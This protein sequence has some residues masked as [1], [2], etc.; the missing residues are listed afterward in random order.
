MDRISVVTPTFNRPAP[1]A[2]ALASLMAQMGLEDLAPELIVV[3]D[4]PDSNARALVA[5]LGPGSPFPLQYVSERRPGVA[6]ARNA[7]VAVA[8]G[9]WVAFLD[10]DEEAEPCWLAS[11][12]RVARERGAAAVFGPIEARAEGGDIGPFAPFFERR[13]DRTSGAEITDFSAISAPII[14]CSTVS[15][16]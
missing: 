1:L 15:P 2:R 8:E 4:S 6:N 10:D 9:R 16:A 13:I 5:S 3:D 14:P 7:G 11:L 12:A